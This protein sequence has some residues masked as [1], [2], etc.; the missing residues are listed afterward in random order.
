MPNNE[1]SS[2]KPDFRDLVR[3]LR[4]E[5]K[6]RDSWKDILESATGQTLI[7]FI[8]SIGTFLHFNLERQ[9]PELFLLTAVTDSGIRANSSLLGVDMSRKVS[10]KVNVDLNLMS[11][12]ETIAIPARSTFAIGNYNF[13]NPST[14]NF[15]TS[16]LRGIELEQGSIASETFEGNGRNFQS[17][18]VSREFRA[19]QNLM[20]VNVDG[21]EPFTRE[22]KSLWGYE[23]GS[24]V[25]LEKTLP[26]GRV[27]ITFPDTNTGF[28][29]GLDSNVTITYADCDGALANN[30]NMSLPVRLSST[31]LDSSGNELQISGKTT[32][33]ISGGLNEEDNEF[34]RYTSPRIFA[35]G[36]R[37]IRRDDWKALG[38]KFQGISGGIADVLVYGE[39]EENS[40]DNTLLNTVKVLLLP[41]NPI[42]VEED[43]VLINTPGEPTRFMSSPATPILTPERGSI[44]VT[45]GIE[46]LTDDGLGT[47]FSDQTEVSEI[48]SLYLIA[49]VNALQTMY[50]K[51]SALGTNGQFRIRHGSQNTGLIRYNSSNSQIESAI[52]SLSNVADVLVTGGGSISDPWRIEFLDPEKMPVSDLEAWNTDLTSPDTNI[53]VNGGAVSGRSG[54]ND[55]QSLYL[56]N[57]DGG[58]FTI[59]SGSQRSAAIDYNTSSSNLQ[60]ILISDISSVI[61]V[62][63]SGT[64]ADPWLIDFGT[65]SS[66]SDITVD[67]SLLTA[68]DDGLSVDYVLNGDKRDGQSGGS[69]SVNVEGATTV[70]MN[71]NASAATLRSS[72][73][74]LA[75]VNNVSVTGAGTRAN[76]WLIDFLDIN[77]TSRPIEFSVNDSE[78]NS[79]VA[80]GKSVV[81]T[82]RQGSVVGSGSLTGNYGQT[83][84]ANINFGVSNFNESDVNLTYSSQLLPSSVKLA[85]EEYMERFKHLTTQ[86]IIEDPIAIPANI[87]IE[88]R[89]FEGNDPSKVRSDTELVIRNL[90]SRGIGSL[91]KEIPLS[92]IIHMVTDLPSV[93]YVR[94][95][96]PTSA[97][98]V[99]P[100]DQD[101]RNV[102]RKRFPKL[103]SLKIN[104]LLTDR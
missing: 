83:N 18:T 7:E 5:L 97:I 88:V 72:L 81:S 35:S 37:A 29:P 69:F 24:R 34:I 13:Y 71:F 26:D 28:I 38:L 85:F 19:N 79:L 39:Y 16:V 17:F 66:V 99:R 98:N 33:P 96:S 49:G 74:S 53:V 1:L 92:D 27:E 40:N 12:S 25:F 65:D 94:L 103:G 46:T 104:T 75:D 50:I 87:E 90:F 32:S 101:G 63:G 78:I 20:V 21:S 9:I 15:S 95:T 44:I 62:E 2:L 68:L 82:V 10:S 93:D 41:K 36:E 67:I 42:A 52:E 4:D 48:K 11:T 43:V 56:S 58:T 91:G 70:N 6:T 64:R 102:Q 57:A 60:I 45:N 3:Q 55:V 31:I 14:I 23:A 86:M 73:I 30:Q 84:S 59:T 76:P 54:F 89:Y 77:T 47:F 61:T 51:G 100:A 8:A 80:V 22:L